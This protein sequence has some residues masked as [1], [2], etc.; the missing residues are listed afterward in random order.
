MQ[1]HLIDG[2]YELFRAHFGAPSRSAPNGQE[3]GATVG[4]LRSFAALLREPGTTHVAC[5][6]DTVIESFRNEL[7][8]GYKTGEGMEP[9]L[10]A[11]FPLAERASAALGIVTWPMREVEA[12]DALATG[13]ARLRDDERVTRVLLCSP[14]KDLAQCVRGER[15]VGF[16]RRKQE[17]LDETGVLAKFGVSPGSIPDYLA[18]VGDSAD[19]IPGIPRWGAKAAAALLARYE[20]LDAIPEDP[21]SWDIK[22]RGAAGLAE[23]LNPRRDDARLYRTLATLREDAELTP[24]ATLEALAWRGPDQPALV[25]LCAELGVSVPALP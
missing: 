3:V 6:F 20:R 11:Q 23:N 15:V 22:V 4:L 7:F 21:A 17:T 19:G 5:A 18:L 1:V 24:P 25:A 10:L 16:D 14:D 9:A 13:A 8:A 2:T 12:D